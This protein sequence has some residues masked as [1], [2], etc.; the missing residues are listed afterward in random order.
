MK[1]KELR[2]LIR[3]ELQKSSNEFDLYEP[4]HEIEISHEDEIAGLAPGL[5][6]VT[7]IKYKDG[8]YIYILDDQTEV[9]VDSVHKKGYWV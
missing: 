8:D 5:Y 1:L 9:T 6:V 7:G 4:G 3:E 2:K